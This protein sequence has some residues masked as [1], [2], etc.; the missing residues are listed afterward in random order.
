MAAGVPVIGSDSGAIP[1]VIGDGG[2]IAPEGDAEALAAALRD[3]RV[4]PARRAA[5]A[6]KGRARFLARFTHERIAEA[7]VAVY[8]DMLE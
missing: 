3:L 6:E 5:L 2:L 1:G 7:T 8:R 4:Q